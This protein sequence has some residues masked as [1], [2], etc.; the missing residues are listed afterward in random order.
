MNLD[1]INGKVSNDEVHSLMDGQIPNNMAPQNRLGEDAGII[2]ASNNLHFNQQTGQLSRD[3]TPSSFVSNHDDFSSQPTSRNFNE[4]GNQ[5]S[6]ATMH[7]KP[8]PI[9]F[10]PSHAANAPIGGLE[11]NK[12]TDSLSENAQE[13][14]NDMLYGNQGDH[15]GQPLTTDKTN[16]EQLGQIGV[17]GENLGQL[18]ETKNQEKEL[19]VEVKKALHNLNEKEQGEAVQEA[20]NDQRELKTAQNIADD[21]P[22]DSPAAAAKGSLTVLLQH[23]LFIYH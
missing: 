14:P 7:E 12:Q 2:P 15:F 10:N 20:L 13:F 16:G 23:R 18:V 22:F 19:D 17:N 9:V 6:Y 8:S 21:S 11:N 5:D 4:L 3:P 1:L